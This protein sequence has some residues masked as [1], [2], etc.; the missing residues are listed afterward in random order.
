MF[1]IDKSK[2]KKSVRSDSE[3]EDDEDQSILHSLM[4]RQFEELYGRALR[5]SLAPV[6]FR[7][8]NPFSG[9]EF[10]TASNAA[11]YMTPEKY[12]MTPN[13]GVRSGKESRVVV[14]VVLEG[15]TYEWNKLRASKGDFPET[16]TQ[17]YD[18]K[19]YYYFFNE[20]KNTKTLI[21]T[22]KHSSQWKKGNF[23]LV[24]DGYPVIFQG[25]VHP[26]TGKNFSL[27]PG[28]LDEK[29][30]MKRATMP[31]WLVE[32]CMSL[33]EDEKSASDDETKVTTK[34]YK[35]GEEN[36]E[37]N[38]RN[39]NNTI[40]N[41]SI[42]KP[43]EKKTGPKPEEEKDKFTLDPEEVPK[44]TKKET[45]APSE[46]FKQE[47]QKAVPPPPEKL[48]EEQKAVLPLSET[49]KEEKKE[50]KGQVP[51]EKK[52][53]EVKCPVEPSRPEMR[54]ESV[55]DGA[56]AHEPKLAP[57]NNPSPAEPA[58]QERGGN[59]AG[60]CKRRVVVIP[61]GI[62]KHDYFQLWLQE[63]LLGKYTTFLTSRGFLPRQ[64]TYG[65]YEKSCEASILMNETEFWM[66]FRKAVGVKKL[67]KRSRP[68]VKDKNDKYIEC[69]QV[70]SEKEARSAFSTYMH[71]EMFPNLLG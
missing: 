69:I 54:Y 48:K 5:L 39:V 21:S 59:A 49:P 64:K 68:K 3:E 53:D 45:V 37:C 60:V 25:S 57:R 4:D 62:G 16:Y 50:S 9:W 1:G 26:S 24:T 58:L 14:F 61:D 65:N 20:D 27:C 41:K 2:K 46:N 36:G 8:L 38:S 52:E 17:H 23:H 44:P 56:G 47:E 34:Q 55:S 19:D 70:P 15:G 63:F 12:D 33:V 30:M 28:S 31:A 51:E 6:P 71:K 42:P 67:E 29:G 40:G 11:E 35:K 43:T 10:I 18:Y 32:F 7:G 22:V 13:V 66:A